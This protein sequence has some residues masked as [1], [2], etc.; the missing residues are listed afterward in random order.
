MPQGKDIYG[1]EMNLHTLQTQPADLSWLPQMGEVALVIVGVIAIAFI[2]VKKGLP[3]I[4]EYK[5]EI[6]LAK[7]NIQKAKN[8]CSD[9]QERHEI[10][11][12][13]IEKLIVDEQKKEK[14]LQE[15]VGRRFNEVES[16]IEDL[17]SIIATHEELFGPL[18]QGTLENMLFTD[19]VP[20]FRRLKSF[21]RLIAM[22]IN[23]RVK[24]KGFDLILQNKK[25]VTDAA[26]NKIKIDPWLD[27]LETMPK[28][29]LK[30]V[31]Q[32]HFDAVLDEI[33][34]RFY[35]GMMR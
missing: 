7:L 3:K 30:I 5:K 4:L 26:G 9:L 25:E 33:N 21:L 14:E 17:M 31:N 34:H 11:L 35:D 8:L 20:I 15:F 13:T 6:G 27:V 29:H 12:E 32:Q 10:Q 28:L 2:F 22:G 19:T 24:Q 1:G 18:S 16:K 23:G